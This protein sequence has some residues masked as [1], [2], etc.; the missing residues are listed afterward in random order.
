MSY[1]KVINTEVEIEN[2]LK[3]IKD[4]LYNYDYNWDESEKISIALREILLNSLIHGN[5]LDAT[6][7]VEIETQINCRFIEIIVTDEGCGFDET[8][9]SDPTNYEHLKEMLDNNDEKHYTHGRGIWLAK[10]LMDKVKF[11]NSGKTVSLHK[12]KDKVYTY[13]NYKTPIDNM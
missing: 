5:K 11:L 3:Y 4:A 7:N 8:S 12:A 10:Q 6:R 1:T 2:V 13:N 9:I